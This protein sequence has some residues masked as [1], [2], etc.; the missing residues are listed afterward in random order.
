MFRH[1]FRKR[2][3]TT[4]S[5]PASR[6][7]SCSFVLQSGITQAKGPLPSGGGARDSSAC[8]S[9][10]AYTT[11]WYG[12]KKEKRR[13]TTRV[14]PREEAREAQMEELCSCENACQPA[15]MSSY[16][17]T[18]TDSFLVIVYPQRTSLWKGSFR[19]SSSF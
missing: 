10:G 12:R 18:L 5:K 19:R 2:M 15:C 13:T 4:A 9:F 6:M 17:L 7:S 8:F 3:K 14:I 11:V 1:M 16:S